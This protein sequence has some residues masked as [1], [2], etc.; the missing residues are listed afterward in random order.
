MALS[1]G[2][3]AHLAHVFANGTIRYLFTGI[4]ELG[5]DFGSVV[6]LLGTIIDLPDFLL[7]GVL[8]LLSS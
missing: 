1:I 6:V 2:R 5:G 3:D 4:A 8:S 7:D